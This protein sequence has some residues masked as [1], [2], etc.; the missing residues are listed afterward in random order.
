MSE[1]LKEW[2]QEGERRRYGRGTEGMSAWFSQ[3]HKRMQEPK[4]KTKT[5]QKLKSKKKKKNV[6]KPKTVLQ[7]PKPKT[8]P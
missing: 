1:F 7:K 4:I 3:N 6:Q 5:N 8:K 2:V